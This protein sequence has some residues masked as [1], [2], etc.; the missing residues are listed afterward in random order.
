MRRL[1]RAVEEE[2]KYV[3]LGT[4]LLGSDWSVDAAD[5]VGSCRGSSGWATEALPA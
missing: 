3:E 1:N 2:E 4:K 5:M